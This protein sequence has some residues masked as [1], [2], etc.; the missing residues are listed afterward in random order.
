M[1]EPTN[2]NCPFKT[3]D[4]PRVRV[5][6]T[7][8]VYVHCECLAADKQGR[9]ASASSYQEYAQMRAELRCE[10]ATEAPSKPAPKTYLVIDYQGSGKTLAAP[11]L[12]LHLGVKHVVDDLEECVW[13]AE[14]E[15]GSLV[16]T[17]GSPSNVPEDVVV[18]SLAG[19]LHLV[20]EKLEASS[21]QRRAAGMHP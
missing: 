5:P 14:I 1:K 20:I 15:P 17:N 10:M 3:C 7:S 11:L 18:L 9:P 19:A 13:P 16:L 6:Y 2:P 21:A 8:D 4:G 12:R